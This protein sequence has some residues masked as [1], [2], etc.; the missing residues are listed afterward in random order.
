MQSKLELAMFLA[1]IGSND[2]KYT[3]SNGLSGLEYPNIGG[4]VSD[5]IRVSKSLLESVR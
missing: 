1:M 2:T 4:S 3:F 5:G